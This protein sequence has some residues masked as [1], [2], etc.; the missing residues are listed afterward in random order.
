MQARSLFRWLLIL[1]VVGLTL[2]AATAVLPASASESQHLTAADNW[3]FETIDDT[4]YV[5]QGVSLAIDA[6]GMPHVAYYDATHQDLKYAYRDLTGWHIEL[7]DS[8]GNVGRAPVLVITTAG[9]PAISYYD[10]SSGHLKVAYRVA[11]RWHILPL[12]P[13]ATSDEYALAMAKDGTVHIAYMDGLILRY[14][15]KQPGQPPDQDTIAEGW[16]FL[17][18]ASI[19][20]SPRLV[21]DETGTPHASFIKRSWLLH[22]F[23]DEV[24]YARRTNDGWEC[25]DVHEATTR[26]INTQDLAVDGRNQPSLMVCDYGHLTTVVST[27]SGWLATR[28]N[29]PGCGYRL[30]YALD[31][32]GLGRAAFQAEGLGYAEQTASGWECEIFEFGGLVGEDV[33]L[34][35]GDQ[36]QVYIAFYDAL[37]HVLKIATGH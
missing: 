19:L 12:A 34:A 32:N 9:K 20:R 15:R 21:V 3:Q 7:V 14:V 35:L 28:L 13:I 4:G 10:A 5:G 25:G 6:A 18:T 37:H 36:N 33:D 29:S 23:W 16:I 22:L 27:D 17:D 26:S 31:G 8:T 11:R 2:M 24:K 30:S 1:L